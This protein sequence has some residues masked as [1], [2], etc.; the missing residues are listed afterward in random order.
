MRIAP[1][2]ILLWK[3]AVF[4]HGTP[5]WCRIASNEQGSGPEGGTMIYPSAAD[6]VMCIATTPPALR[7][8]VLVLPYLR[9][10]NTERFTIA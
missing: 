1:G 4:Q 5:A 8:Y 6:S 2:D 9:W 10:I 7:I 3:R